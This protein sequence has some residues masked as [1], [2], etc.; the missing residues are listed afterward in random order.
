MKPLAVLVSVCPLREQ[1][2]VKFLR[3]IHLGYEL[4]E[5]H[6]LRAGFCTDGS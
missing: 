4:M 1:V 3:T 6:F 5:S 2:M